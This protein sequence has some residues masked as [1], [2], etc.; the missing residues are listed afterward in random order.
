MIIRTID[1]KIRNAFSDASI[2]YDVL[3]GLHKEIGRELVNK[4]KH[5]EDAQAILD[6]GMGTGWLT[7]RLSYFFPD[8]QVIGLDFA[9]GM[10]DAA[11][12]FN[13]GFAIVQADAGALPFQNEVFD[14]VISNLAYQ[15][16]ENTHQAFK[17]CHASLKGN[18]I[19][20]F[21]MFG[22]NTLNELFISLENSWDNKDGLMQLPIR[23]LAKQSDIRDALTEADFRDID[24]DYER[25]KVHFPDMMSLMKWIKNIGANALEKEM[26][27]G[28][29]L[30]I[31]ADEY[32]N[33]HFKDHL[34]ICSTFEV[35][36]GMARK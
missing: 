21:T 12:K 27:I 6:V 14:I 33:T 36:W 4:I 3:T 25:I 30:L 22:Y 11:K 32:Y 19:F 15:W 17:S 35:I 7:N 26:Y 34:G 20:C 9:P 13:E 10:I 23:R 16:V 8:A 24:V 18:G 2:Q 29:D 1:R 31:R 28:K 5:I